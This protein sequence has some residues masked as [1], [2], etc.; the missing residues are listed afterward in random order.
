MQVLGVN[1]KAPDPQCSIR[2]SN[3][4][5]A[6]NQCKHYFNQRNELFRLQEGSFLMKY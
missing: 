4:P 2:S 1:D 5:P 3:L 6:L